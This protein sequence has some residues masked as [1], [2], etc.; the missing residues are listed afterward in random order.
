MKRFY[1]LLFIIL[2]LFTGCIQEIDYLSS[3]QINQQPIVNCFFTND[4]IFKVYI[5]KTNEIF[6]TSSSEIVVDKIII[7]SENNTD[8]FSLHKNNNI[9][10][11][12]KIAE[13]NINYILNIETKEFGILTAENKIPEN[14]VIIDT[15]I[16]NDNVY[17]DAESQIYSSATI[18]FSDNPTEENY[19]EISILGK[20]H[21]LNSNSD[22]VYTLRYSN[23]LYSEDLIIKAENY[24]NIILP[25]LILSDKFVENSDISLNINFNIPLSSRTNYCWDGTLIFIVKSVSKDYYEYR[26]SLLLHKDELNIYFNFEVF[27]NMMFVRKNIA[28]ESNIAGALGIFAG[29][30]LNFYIINN[31]QLPNIY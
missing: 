1:L 5:G 13:K 22:T 24:D 31:P 16:F 10:I 3:E 6:N 30:N 19:Y 26:K 28:I 12:D 27:T 20:D 25:Y 14:N 11:S 18:K 7:T 15:V 23:Q 2:Q 8:T 4:S 29:Y 17:N 9:Y 21:H